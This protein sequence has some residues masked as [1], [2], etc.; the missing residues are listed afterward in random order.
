VIDADFF[1][2]FFIAY[3]G[4]YADHRGLQR[5]TNDLQVSVIFA[6]D[7]EMLVLAWRAGPGWTVLLNEDDEM[8]AV[9]T[10][11]SQRSRFS[12]AQHRP[13]PHCQG[14]PSALR[15]WTQAT[16]RQPPAAGRHAYSTP[17]R[18]EKGLRNH[19]RP[20]SAAPPRNRI[21]KGFSNDLKPTAETPI[22]PAE[23]E[24]ACS[25]HAGRIPRAS[26]AASRP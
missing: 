1:R 15:Q 7:T 11:R 21:T 3:V 8:H 24:V 25:N 19:A 12:R 26:P 23:A 22:Y 9:R 13:S 17:K 20:V 10:R 6:D 5:N 2:E 4:E 14:H 16:S 18:Q